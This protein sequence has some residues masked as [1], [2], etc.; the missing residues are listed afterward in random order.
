MREENIYFLK[1]K[2]H[3]FCPLFC[4]L[5]YAPLPPAAPSL[6]PSPFPQLKLLFI[7]IESLSMQSHVSPL[8]LLLQWF[9]SVESLQARPVN[10]SIFVQ[11]CPFETQKHKCRKKIGNV[12]ACPVLVCPWHPRPVF[13]VCFSVH[14]PYEGILDPQSALPFAKRTKNDS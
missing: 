13:K 5:S 12:F 11:F 9:L 7:A 10:V 2:V 8:H 6:A 1:F 4:L 3:I 14:F